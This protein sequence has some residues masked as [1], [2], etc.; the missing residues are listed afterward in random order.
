MN[1]YEIDRQ[2]FRA[3]FF[4]SMPVFDFAGKN[5]I[6]R[7]QAYIHPGVKNVKNFPKFVPALSPAVAPPAA[8]KLKPEVPD[9]VLAETTSTK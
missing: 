5:R 6:F 9:A 4:N 1:I 8:R 7:Q 2:D 3:L